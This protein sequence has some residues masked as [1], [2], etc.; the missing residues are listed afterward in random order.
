MIIGGLLYGYHMYHIEYSTVLHI[1]EL[2]L[3]P[4]SIL[5]TF[6]AYWMPFFIL[7]CTLIS[8]PHLLMD[9]SRHSFYQ[10]LSCSLYAMNTAK[11]QLPRHTLLMLYYTLIYPHLTYG[12]LLWGTSSETWLKQVEILQKKAVRIIT[13]STYND[14]TYAFQR[15]KVIKIVWYI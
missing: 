12:I 8:M 1:T 9:Y 7:L 13:K 15:T 4:V 5:P 3:R 11:H 6:K 10:Q 14:H 2:I